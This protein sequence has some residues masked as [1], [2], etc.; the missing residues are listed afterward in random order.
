MKKIISLIVVGFLVLG[1]GC[2]G[3]GSGNSRDVSVTI[4]VPQGWRQRDIQG[5]IVLFDYTNDQGG[6]FFV[7]KEGAVGKNLAEHIVHKKSFYEEQYGN[8]EWLGT[9]E[10]SIDGRP[11]QE[12]T[13]MANDLKNKDAYVWIGKNVFRF[14]IVTT[15]AIFDDI[16]DDY[17]SILKSAKFK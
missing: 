8:V 4:E 6:F 5:Q 17:Y 11:A 12:I 1:A 13:Y 10:L 7:T 2:G 15:E 3:S 14:N 16:H 9:A